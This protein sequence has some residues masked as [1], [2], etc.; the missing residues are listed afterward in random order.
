MNYLIELKVKAEIEKAISDAVTKDNGDGVM[1]SMSDLN[2][3]V[4][5]LLPIIIQTIAGPFVND[6]Y[7]KL[8]S[9]IKDISKNKGVYLSDEDTNNL[10]YNSYKIMVDANEADVTWT[11]CWTL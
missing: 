7:V 10:L 5:W 4:L 3:L 9:R 1:Y 2:D 8:K 6:L 11:T